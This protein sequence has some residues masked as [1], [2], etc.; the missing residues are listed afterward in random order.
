[1]LHTIRVA[2]YVSVAAK[3][4][5]D[6]VLRTRHLFVVAKEWNGIAAETTSTEPLA[7]AFLQTNNNFIGSLSQ[8]VTALVRTTRYT[9]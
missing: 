9:R 6:Q 4:T 3:Y 5:F 2:G 7:L 1:M 8:D